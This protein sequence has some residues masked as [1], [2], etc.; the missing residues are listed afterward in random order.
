M[1]PKKM[2][3]VSIDNS[4]PKKFCYNGNQKKWDIAGQEYEAPSKKDGNEN[5]ILVCGWD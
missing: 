3:E 1:R 2:K 5:S 4:F